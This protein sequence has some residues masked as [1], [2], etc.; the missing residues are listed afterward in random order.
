MGWRWALSHKQKL[1]DGAS[2]PGRGLAMSLTRHYAE[3]FLQTGSNGSSAE[4][5]PNRFKTVIFKMVINNPK[6]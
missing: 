2:E 6:F 5:S 3:Q 4:S 1:R